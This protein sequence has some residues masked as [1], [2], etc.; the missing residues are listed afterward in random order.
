MS[1]YIIKYNAK[2]DAIPGGESIE[3][4]TD[5][6]EKWHEKHNKE[7]KADGQSEEGWD[8]FDFDDTYPV[9][10]DHKLLKKK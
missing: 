2:Y 6:P 4:I 8:E 1:L 7:R 9:L 5:N 3:G 10:F